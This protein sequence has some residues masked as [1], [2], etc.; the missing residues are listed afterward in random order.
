MSDAEARAVISDW[1]DEEVMVLRAR[2]LG[3]DD[4]DPIVRRRLV[5]QMRFLLEDSAP[6]GEPDEATLLDWLR[7]HPDRYR[8]PERVSFEHVFF[9]R[10]VRGEDIAAA[11]ARGRAQLS[12]DAAD[13]AT[14]GDPFF[15]RRSM[16]NA[17]ERGI[18]RVFGRDFASAVISRAPGDWS[19]PSRRPMA[20][21]SCV[22]PTA[23]RRASRRSTRS[24]GR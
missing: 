3:L 10:S 12:R 14:V 19:P 18:A 21:T 1:I 9:S 15:G 11:A 13:P 23:P 4:R 17:D 8:V 5:S 2:E 16:K 22:S 6:I 20:C 7:T 24:A